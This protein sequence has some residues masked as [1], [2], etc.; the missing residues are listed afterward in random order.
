MEEGGDGAEASSPPS[1]I[2]LKYDKLSNIL[3]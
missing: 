3:S 1:I 2:V